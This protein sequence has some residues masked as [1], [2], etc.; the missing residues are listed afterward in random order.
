MNTD[1]YRLASEVFSNTKYDALT[2][3]RE[4]ELV[5]RVKAGDSE[6]FRDLCLGYAGGLRRQMRGYR[7]ESWEDARVEALVAFW[8]VIADHD[9]TKR[10]AYHLRSVRRSVD[11]RDQATNGAV[12]L[13][14]SMRQ[15]YARLGR[16]CDWETKKMVE[17]ASEVEMSAWSVQAV[18]NLLATASIEVGDGTYDLPDETP[19]YG[20]GYEDSDLVDLAFASI[21]HEPQWTDA[22]RY[23]FGFEDEAKRIRSNGEVAE[24]VGVGVNK[25]GRILTD[26]LHTMRVALG[27]QTEGVV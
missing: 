23:K 11:L 13:S 7:G 20:P 19:L 1:L 25:A 22:C 24:H 14:P 5:E 9:G 3:E 15:R 18:T 8:E 27:V 12:E 4:T 16:M 10:L 6:A 2:P 17:R 21:A 26:S